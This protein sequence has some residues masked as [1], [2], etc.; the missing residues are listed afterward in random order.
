VIQDVWTNYIAL[1]VYS[2]QEQQQITNWDNVANLTFSGDDVV[3]MS[4]LARF[5]TVITIFYSHHYSDSVFYFNPTFPHIKSPYE[6]TCL[7]LQPLIDIPQNYLQA[8][9]GRAKSILS[10]INVDSGSSKRNST[11]Y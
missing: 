8:L 2:V 4:R 7:L 10:E 3:Y 1:S 9:P 5:V 6:G 11:S